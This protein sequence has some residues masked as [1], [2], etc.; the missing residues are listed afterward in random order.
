MIVTPASV[1]GWERR[2]GSIV[3]YDVDERTHPAARQRRAST[4][5]ARAARRSSPCASAS[6]ASGPRRPAA[7]HRP[8]VTRRCRD[9][10]RPDVEPGSAGDVGRPRGGVRRTV[11]QRRDPRRPA[12][13]PGLDVHRARSRPRHQGQAPQPRTAEAAARPRRRRRRAD[14]DRDRRPRASTRHTRAR[15]PGC[16]ASVGAATRRS[17]SPSPATRRRGPAG[18]LTKIQI[19]GPP[20]VT[21]SSSSGG[22]PLTIIND[23]TQRHPRRRRPRLQQPCAQPARRSSRSTSRAGERHTLTVNIDLGRQNTTQLTASLV[24]ADGT[25]FGAP[26]VFNVRSSRIGVVLWVAIGLAGVL[27]LVALFRRFH[28][29]LAPSSSVRAAGRR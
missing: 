2:L 11:R 19:E 17:A 25:T 4:R 20:S 24:S 21:L 6:S 1:P 15:S 10:G 9:H 28:R 8:D 13:A 29:P 16:S 14:L 26:A 18:E 27:V 23:T 3:S 12:G 5:R 22:F 7:R